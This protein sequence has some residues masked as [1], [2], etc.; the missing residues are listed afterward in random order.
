MPVVSLAPCSCISPSRGVKSNEQGKREHHMEIE[1]ED[2]I[3]ARKKNVLKKSNTYRHVSQL[4]I[5]VKEEV[6]PRKRKCP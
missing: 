5:S 1:A 4:L 6:F 3:S 2:V